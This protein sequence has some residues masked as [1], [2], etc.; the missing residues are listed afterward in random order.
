MTPRQALRL[1]TRGG[2]RTLGR[3]DI[4]QIKVGH[5][6]DLALFRTDTVGM[7]G[8]AVHDPIGALLLCSSQNADYTLVNG[9]VV[10]EKG[11]LKTLE[12]PKLIG[13]HNSLASRLASSM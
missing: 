10:V 13:Q 12:L 8:G 11:E 1:A 7:A 9:K 3:D 5:C 6:A 2:A 4:G